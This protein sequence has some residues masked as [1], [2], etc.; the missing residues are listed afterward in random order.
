MKIVRIDNLNKNI[1][2]F[3][4]LLSTTVSSMSSLL[5]LIS[6][7]EIYSRW[8]FKHGY[9]HGSWAHID[10]NNFW[11]VNLMMSLTTCK[12]HWYQ[13]FTWKNV[14]S[15]AHCFNNIMFNI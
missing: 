14:K 2:I 3:M 7:S 13:V 4:I 10:S 8:S 15:T 5:V 1:N 6:Y 11:V 9:F 12:F